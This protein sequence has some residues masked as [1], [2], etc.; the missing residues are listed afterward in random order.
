ML[1]FHQYTFPQSE[2]SYIIID[3]GSFLDL[4]SNGTDGQYF[5]GSEIEFVSKTVIE[6]YTRIR[7]GW[8]KKE[9]PMRFILVTKLILLQIN[10]G[11]L[12]LE[13]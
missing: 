5:V 12:N 3:A 11:L 7:G 10:S 6:G 2:D 4:P 9:M 8:G 1:E 13:K